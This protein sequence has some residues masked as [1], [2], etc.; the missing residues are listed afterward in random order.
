MLEYL[1]DA[2]RL[3]RAVIQCAVGNLRSGAVPE[4]IGFTK[5]GVLRH[6]QLLGNRWLDLAV[7]SMLEEEWR[8]RAK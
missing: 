1:F 5:E 6:A 3:H 4:R 7:W 2:K 8:G